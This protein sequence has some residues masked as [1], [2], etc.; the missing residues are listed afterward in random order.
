MKAL[1]KLSPCYGRGGGRPDSVSPRQRFLMESVVDATEASE[2]HLAH[3]IFYE[4]HRIY[5]WKSLDVDII[6]CNSVNN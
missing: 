1:L 3:K 6:A 4:I 5:L 2:D